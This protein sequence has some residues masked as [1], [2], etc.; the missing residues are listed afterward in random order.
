MEIINRQYV[1]RLKS[2]RR[3]KTIIEISKSNLKNPE[4]P[5]SQFLILKAGRK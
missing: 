1:M 2:N 3:E 5:R 4:N